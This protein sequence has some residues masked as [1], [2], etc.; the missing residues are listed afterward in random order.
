M[1]RCIVRIVFAFLGGV[2]LLCGVTDVAS[3]AK[4]LPFRQGEKMI[5]QARWGVIPA[6]EAVIEILPEESLNGTRAWHFA[7][8]T[9]TNAGMDVFCRVR[10]RKDSFMDLSLQRTLLYREKE[11]GNHS[12]DVVVNYDWATGT[13]IR[14]ENGNRGDMISIPPGTIDP[15]GLFFF[16]R[17]NRLQPGQVLEFPVTDGKKTWDVK[18]TVVCREPLTINGRAHDTILVIPDMRRL[19]DVFK[20]KDEQPDLKIWFSADE[21]QVLVRIESRVVIGTFV[22]E[23]MSATF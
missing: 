10:E 21:R 1:H 4:G 8:T 11:E 6:G 13:A 9:T 23:L 3:A 19:E 14:Y 7:M 2:V 17:M 15:L 22:F 16:I 18:A 20:Q 5:Y 12:R